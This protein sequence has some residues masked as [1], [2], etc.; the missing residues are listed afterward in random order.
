M[1]YLDWKILL[2]FFQFG[3][4]K[5][6]SKNRQFWDCSFCRYVNSYIC[7]LTKINFP[8]FLF[9]ILVTRTSKFGDSTFERF[10]N[11]RFR[12]V[13][14]SKKINFTIRKINI[15]QFEK[16]FLQYCKILMEYFRNIPSILRCY[17]GSVSV[18]LL[19]IYELFVHSM[20]RTVR[21]FANSHICHLTKI[22]FPQFLFPILVTRTN[23]FGDSTFERFVNFQ[24]RVGVKILNDEM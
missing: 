21:N 14:H 8:Q 4:P 7:R 3:K 20:F 6:G 10:V 19:A 22:N 2:E 16:L 15:L 17:V 1:N 24:F 12:N 23:K 9:P 18:V 5:F 11:F 13:D